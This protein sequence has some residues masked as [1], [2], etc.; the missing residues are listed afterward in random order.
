MG[1]VDS[2]GSHTP[3]AEGLC[4]ERQGLL[5]AR[6][7]GEGAV[8][9]SGKRAL[10]IWRGRWEN[11]GDTRG[12]R[13]LGPALGREKNWVEGESSFLCSLEA[14]VELLQ[15]VGPYP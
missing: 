10:G 13:A 9:W 5:E 6:E 4:Q 7:M 14:L 11:E 15:G 1:G 12:R 2:E 3:G 8:G